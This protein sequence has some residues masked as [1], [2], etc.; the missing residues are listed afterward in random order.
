[1]HSLDQRRRLHI[2]TANHE[3]ARRPSLLDRVPDTG[4]IARESV[5]VDDPVEDWNQHIRECPF[6][7]ECSLTVHVDIRG[8]LP[9][10]IADLVPSEKIAN[11]DGTLGYVVDEALGLHNQISTTTSNPYSEVTDRDGLVIRRSSDQ[12]AR[13]VTALDDVSP[14]V[15]SAERL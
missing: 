14:A 3:V 10:E 11:V 9:V 12:R 6:K 15:V 13:R 2:D 5:V 8:Q 4:I 1:M 7:T